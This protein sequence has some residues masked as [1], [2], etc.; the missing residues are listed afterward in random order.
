MPTEAKEQ[1][2]ATSVLLVDD[3]VELCSMLGT[4]LNSEG[5]ATTFAHD[6]QNGLYEALSGA[7]QMIV[8][9]IMLSGG[10]GRKVLKDVRARSSVPIIM[11]TASGE[12]VDRISGLDSGA[13]DYLAKPFEPGEL[14]ARMRAVLRRH[15]APQ[16]IDPLLVGDITVEIANR[17]V[18]RDGETVEFTS[19]EFDLL[20][21]LLLHAGRC[22]SRNDLAQRA[23][24]RPVGPLDRS[25]DNYMSILRRKLGPHHSG[26]DRI[27]NIRS[28]GYCYT[29]D[30]DA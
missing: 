23:L 30:S 12:A 11:L 9:D 1:E 5:F 14:I 16:T 21:V 22:V 24:G 28:I 27:R 4:I 13:D 17:H 6:A 2:T 26:R 29:G 20:L 19:G 25:I 3:D 15:A 10:D 18:R 7:Y 8:L